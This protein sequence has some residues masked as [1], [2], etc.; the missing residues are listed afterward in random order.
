VTRP[1]AQ[2]GRLRRYRDGVL[3]V[4]WIGCVCSMVLSGCATFGARPDLPS[5]DFRAA[6]SDLPGVYLESQDPCVDSLK[7]SGLFRAVGR[8][9]EAPTAFVELKRRQYL[10]PSLSGL[11]LSAITLFIVPARYQ[12]DRVVLHATIVDRQSGRREEFVVE[13]QLSTW[14]GLLLFPVTLFRLPSVEAKRAEAS[15]CEEL[16]IRLRQTVERFS[17][18]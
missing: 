12:T 16:A 8:S 11:V 5:H 10:E 9:V 4:A 17:L 3:V 18:A 15:L 6:G 2:K 7:A 1:S 14:G 13:R